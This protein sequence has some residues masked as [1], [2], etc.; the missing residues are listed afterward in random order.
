MSMTGNSLE[1]LVKLGIAKGDS[2]E[3]LN[4]QIAEIQK[5]LKEIKVDIKIDPQAIRSLDTLANM[6][7]SKLVKS[8]N[9]IKGAMEGVGKSSKPAADQIQRDFKEIAPA[10]DATFGHL[11]K[12]LQQAMRKGITS[13]EELKVA[14]K[15]LDPKFTVGK[16]IITKNDQLTAEKMVNGITVSYRNLQGQIEKVK[17]TNKEFI[18]MGGG[19]LQ[20]IFQPLGDS[21]LIDNSMASIANLGR[22]TQASLTKMR[23]EGKITAAQF[24]ELSKAIERAGN[25]QSGKTA[26]ANFARLNQRIQESVQSTK[27]FDEAQ[28]ATEAA[29]KRL[30]ANENK[31]KVLIIDIEKAIRTQGKGYDMA[32]AQNLL[33]QTKGLDTSS[34]NFG[35]TIQA[36]RTQLKQFNSEAA[37]GTRNN[38][39]MVDAFKQ[40]M[41]KFPIWMLSSTLFF[42][43]TRSAREFGRIIVDIDSKM[44][45][46]T[47]VMT[48]DT[49]FEGLFD[50]ATESAE[51]FGQSISQ[52]M[53][54]YIE[55][56]R[57]GYKGEE[58]GTLADAGLVASNVG[59]ISAQQA[60][61]Y[62]T[63]SLIQWKKDS[64]DAMSV[65]DSWNEIANNYATT[66]EKVAAGQARA[67]VSSL[68]LF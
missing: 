4:N 18:D 49:D 30:I 36:N 55:F 38:I 3:N 22:T 13:V 5:Q 7:F 1:L 47:K 39:G 46:L 60:S 33:A 37:T 64:G 54:S 15:G 45:S 41:E 40:A 17:L 58:L 57:Q 68:P 32:G 14:F 6:D 62:M 44:T 51:R 20:P 24:T 53:D 56:A 63:A 12:N 59:E 16:E 28:R 27:K 10:M 67:G 48:Q 21:K 52:V 50:R 43:V 26:E 31:R 11:G 42:G 34:K 2:K 66:V 25:T 65:I 19:K 9:E 8:A 29:Q 61:E 35:Q 23:T